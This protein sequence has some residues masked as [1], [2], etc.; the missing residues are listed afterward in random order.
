MHKREAQ[1]P[2]HAGTLKL[3]IQGTKMTDCEVKGRKHLQSCADDS[4][5][6]VSEAALGQLALASVGPC[7]IEQMIVLDA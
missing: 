3:D 6:A 1:L 4:P 7:V 5:T 2:R